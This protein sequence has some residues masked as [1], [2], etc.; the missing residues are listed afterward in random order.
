MTCHELQEGETWVTYW[1][2]QN[3]YDEKELIRARSRKKILK[4][5]CQ[6]C[7]YRYPDECIFMDTLHPYDRAAETCPD[8]IPKDLYKGET[9]SKCLLKRLE[10]DPKYTTL[11]DGELWHPIYKPF[12]VCSSK[13]YYQIMTKD[14]MLRRIKQKQQGVA[15]Q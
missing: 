11:P 13:L 4:L 8:Y 9:R 6:S 1:Q 15:T 7:C 2:H 10:I 3:D 14:K 12:A 5:Y